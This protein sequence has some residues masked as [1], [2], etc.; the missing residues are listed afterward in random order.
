MKKC[1]EA[2]S[3]YFYKTENSNCNLEHILSSKSPFK[4][5]EYYS[6]G[7]GDLF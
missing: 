6:D 7:Q 1:Q 2:T 4:S 5:L 3:Y